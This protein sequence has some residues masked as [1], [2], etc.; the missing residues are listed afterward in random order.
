MYAIKIKLLLNIRQNKI[1]FMVP[2]VISQELILSKSYVF[3][4]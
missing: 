4:H 2:L 1:I 3:I